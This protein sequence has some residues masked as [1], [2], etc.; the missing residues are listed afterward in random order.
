MEILTYFISLLFALIWLGL[1][2]SV[3]LAFRSL[4]IQLRYTS[5]ARENLFDSIRLRYK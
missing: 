1:G 5:Q 3:V 2:A 4:L